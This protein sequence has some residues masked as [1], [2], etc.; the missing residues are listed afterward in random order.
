MCYYTTFKKIH[1][2]KYYQ[3]ITYYLKNF[4]N[5]IIFFNILLKSIVFFQNLI[6]L[7]IIFIKYKFLF[8][9]FHSSTHPSIK[10][11]DNIIKN[12]SHNLGIINKKTLFANIVLLFSSKIIIN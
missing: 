9:V 2:Y 10:K 3:Y 8:C 6:F 7:V 11:L 1:K 5:L 4:I 12:L